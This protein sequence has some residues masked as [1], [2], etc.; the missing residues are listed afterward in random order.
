MGV[1]VVRHAGIPGVVRAVVPP[2]W[3]VVI[4]G[5]NMVVVNVVGSVVVV[6]VVS[7]TKLEFFW[8]LTP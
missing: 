2:L 7:A 8:R 3:F 1:E 4:K 6:L 5:G